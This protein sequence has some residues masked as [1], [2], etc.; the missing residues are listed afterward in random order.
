MSIRMIIVTEKQFKE[1]KPYLVM[2]ADG[3]WYDHMGTIVRILDKG[4][5]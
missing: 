3:D 4:T 1:L 5:R 2:G